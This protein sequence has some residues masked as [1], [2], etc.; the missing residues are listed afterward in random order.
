MLSRGFAALTPAAR[1]TGNRVLAA[2][3]GALAPLLGREISIRARPAPGVP[4]PR[5]SA[6]TLAIELAALPA[7]A[8]LEVEPAIVVSLVDALAGGNGVAAGASALTPIEASALELLALAALDGACTVAEIEAS[9]A[10]RLTRCVVEPASALVI[11]LELAVGPATGRGRLL[12]PAAAVRALRGAERCEG[13][14][15]GILLPLSVRSGMAPLAPDEIAAFAPGDVVLLDL[16]P[17]VSD[18]LVLPGGS[19]LVGRIEGGTF[20]VEEVRMKAR[21]AELPVVIEVEL[22]R[23]EV[24][25]AEL[26]RLE[27]GAAL[28]L[29][30]DRHGV[31]T[32][33]VGERAIGRGELVDV[34]GTVG[35]RI[36]T[37]EGAP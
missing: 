17:A 35:V 27:P 5:A 32:L 3:A 23:V 37:L 24:P 4:Q 33:R 14:G 20:Q 11:E 29:A 2:A 36:L 28:P 9:L 18:A 26:A 31:V 22:A 6:A 12:V 15:E 7:R 21:T 25:L 19:R 1:E 8:V 30:I 34:D 13:R 16:P 10:P